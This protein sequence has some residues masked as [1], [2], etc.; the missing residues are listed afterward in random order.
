MNRLDE[1]IAAA[2]REG[3]TVSTQFY[4]SQVEFDPDTGKR[5]VMSMMCAELT[6]DG[7]T[8]GLTLSGAPN[9]P[10]EMVER[11]RCVAIKGA[12]ERARGGRGR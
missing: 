8:E 7:I 5:Y 9:P 12:L 4:P 6:K 2:E 10:D 1:A 11:L 3:Y